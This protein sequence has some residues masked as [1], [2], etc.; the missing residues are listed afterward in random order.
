MEFSDKNISHY[1]GHENITLVFLGILIKVLWIA[2]MYY[3]L[4]N[5]ILS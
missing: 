5:Y 2:N 1:C 4:E 3:I